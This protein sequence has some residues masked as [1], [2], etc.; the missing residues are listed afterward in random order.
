MNKPQ[1]IFH[2]L[3]FHRD[4][5]FWAGCDASGRCAFLMPVTP[6]SEFIAFGV[7]EQSKQVHFVARG[8]LKED[9]ED[10][11]TQ[12]VRNGAAVELYVQAPVPPSILKRYTSGPPIENQEFEEPPGPPV[13]GILPDPATPTV[14]SFAGSFWP[15]TELS[16]RSVFLLP[17]QTPSEFLALGTVTS[18]GQVLFTLRGSVQE[19]L[20]AFIHQM[21]DDQAR[22]ELLPSQPEM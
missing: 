8:R 17:T 6:S 9:L 22:V 2:Q 18:V 4:A 5:D 3:E 1:P 21:V 12:M 19:Q 10:F 20:G 11:I 16:A 13:H 14:E 7:L 15:G